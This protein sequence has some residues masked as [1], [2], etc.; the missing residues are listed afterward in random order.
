MTASTSSPTVDADRRNVVDNMAGF[1]AAAS[2]TLSVLAFFTSPALLTPIAAITAFVA[3]RMSHRIERLAMFAMGASV[4][5]FVVAMT[6]AVI[7]DH[8][9]L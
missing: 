8:A 6:I 2:V 7:T 4:V 9:L 5:A 1:L 3:G